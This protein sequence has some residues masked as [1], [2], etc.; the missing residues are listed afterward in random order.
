MQRNGLIIL[1]KVSDM[2]LINIFKKIFK[3]GKFNPK[4]YGYYG[5]KVW[6][7]LNTIITNPNNVY[8]YG[9]NG[10]K[11]AVILSGRGKVVF[12]KNSGASYGLKVSTGNHAR[13][14]GIPYR[15][16][17]DDMKPAGCDGDVIVEEDVWMGFNVTLLSGIIVGRGCTV[18]AG[19]VVTRSL[20]PYCVAAGVPAKFIKFY[21]TIDQILEHESKLYTEDERYSREE[22][23][24]IFSHYNL[25]Y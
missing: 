16:I 9:N 5:D 13:I 7:S 19:S 1:N 15:C 22:L 20:P 14:I 21:W 18:A 6:V 11:H 12:K 23:Q 4:N 3:V 8:L 17:T 2:E 24:N 10:L 25:K